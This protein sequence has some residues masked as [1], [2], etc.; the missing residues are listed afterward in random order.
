MQQ[1][2]SYIN[3]MISNKYE[4]FHINDKVDEQQTLYHYHD[5]Y[6]IHA[7]LAGNATFYLD[8]KKFPIS[9]GT[10]I[11]INHYDLHRI[12]SQK[13]NDFE[14]IYIFLTKQFLQRYSTANT[15]LSDMFSDKFS[16]SS[17][18][19][20]I[21]EDKLKYLLKFVDD[22]P[23]LENFGEDIIYEQKLIQYLIYLNKCLQN[24]QAESLKMNHSNSLINHMLTYINENLDKELTLKVMEKEFFISQSY[25]S[26]VFKKNTGLS[27]YQY[28]LKKR[29]LYSKEQLR[30]YKS[31]NAIYQK[32]GFN[33]YSNFLKA[34]KKEFH[35][36]P[37]EFIK[38]DEAQQ[39]IYYEND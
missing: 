33:S 38:K 27:F 4:I 21:S 14:R 34:F 36:T 31:S 29:L 12:V 1:K 28:V 39:I 20:Q 22:T 15:D 7:T 17:K 16:Q 9:P 19:L 13:S 24:S 2:V 6:E 30:I 37:K 32:C 18:I 25:I 3:S 11:L 5:F 26:K 35:M 23:N 10:V 8:G